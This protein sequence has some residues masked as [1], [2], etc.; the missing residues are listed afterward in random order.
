MLFNSIHFMFFFPLVLAIY[1]IIPKKCRIYW[2]LVASYYFYMSWN[3]KYALLIIFSTL[4]TYA[5]GL[6]IGK[7]AENKNRIKQKRIYVV[8][9]IISNLAILGYFKY[10]NFAVSSACAVLSHVGITVIKSQIDILLPVGISFYTFQALSYTIDVY[11]GEIKAERNLIRYAL[12]VSFFPQ[13]VA[14]PIERSRN[15]LGQMQKISQLKLWDLNRVICG[16]YYMLW[17]YFMKMV[18]ADRAAIFVDEIFDH[19]FLYGTME[20]IL[21]AFWF[22]VQIYCDF[23]GYSMIAIGAA[24]VM[25]FDLMENFDAPYLSCSI[26]EFW[27]RWHIS[28]SSWFK[29]Y[30]YIPLGGN[31]KG[32]VRKYS[33]L[34][35]TF[36]VSGLW[37][38]AAWSFVAWGGLHG[39]YQI[40]GELLMPLRKQ[41]THAFGIKVE[42]FSHKLLQIVSTFVLVDFAWIFFRADS[43]RIAIAYIKRLVTRWNPWVLFDGSIYQIALSRTEMKILVC[44]AILLLGADIIK[45][46]YKKNITDVIR[47]QDTWFAMLSAVMILISIVIWGVY[48]PAYDAAQFIYFQF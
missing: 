36:L 31:R 24:K 35:I 33:N 21:G 9:C 12:F 14:G 41:L 6:L 43:L 37:H 13:L 39:L 45:H 2:L 16:A 4:V 32:T 48:G 22:A 42:S 5:S 3:P 18:I 15:L 29:D 27:R 19:Y 30:L 17:G 25:G 20:L 10:F 1:F 28:L 7:E 44:A 8:G 26:K 40:V 47:M 11:K 38:G 46:H 23:G 34:L